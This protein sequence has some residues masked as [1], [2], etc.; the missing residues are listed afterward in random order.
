VLGSDGC[1]LESI[2]TYGWSVRFQQDLVE[3]R[4]GGAIT[5]TSR[6]GPGHGAS[7][8]QEEA[9]LEER[10]ELLE[11]TGI[12]MQGAA[13]AAMVLDDLEQWLG[14]PPRV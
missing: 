5:N 7:D 1:R 3:G 6:S 2:H 12:R 9:Q 14:C 10:S 13:Q 11:G 8:A 4:T